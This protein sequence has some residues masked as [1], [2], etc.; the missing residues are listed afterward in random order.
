MPHI[1]RVFEGTISSSPPRRRVDTV[2]AVR[3]L[4][5][6]FAAVRERRSATPVS[7]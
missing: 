2:G 1:P 5:P 6:I 3:L 4:H 7:A